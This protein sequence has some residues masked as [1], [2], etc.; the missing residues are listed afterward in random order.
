MRKSYASYIV[1]IYDRLH[2]WFNYTE[3]SN[4]SAFHTLTHRRIQKLSI[5][6]VICLTRRKKLKKESKLIR[7]L[8]KNENICATSKKNLKRTD[9]SRPTLRR[10]YQMFRKFYRSQSRAM[11]QKEILHI[12]LTY[13]RNLP[14]TP[15]APEVTVPLALAVCQNFHSYLA[16]VAYYGECT[17][18]CDSVKKQLNRPLTGWVKNSLMTS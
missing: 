1:N 17:I 6:F 2:A 16:R 13:I 11:N 4:Q 10:I 12:L 15:A 18:R 5:D 9:K 8:A 3:S 14:A 7:E